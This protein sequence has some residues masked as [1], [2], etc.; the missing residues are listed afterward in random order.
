MG[1]K[2]VIDEFPSCGDTALGSF[3]SC[4]SL[5]EKSLAFFPQK[6]SWV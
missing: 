4:L 1:P 2:T 3:P 5:G 6:V